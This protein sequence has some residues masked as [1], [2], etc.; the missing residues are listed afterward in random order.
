MLELA[1]QSKVIIFYE[2]KKDQSSCYI[3]IAPIGFKE[4]ERTSIFQFES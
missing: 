4:V 1:K 3:L 2:R